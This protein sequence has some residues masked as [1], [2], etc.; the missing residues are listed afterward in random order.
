MPQHPINDH[1][2]YLIASPWGFYTYPFFA[3]PEKFRVVN[4]GPYLSFT[5]ARFAGF[6]PYNPVNPCRPGVACSVSDRAATQQIRTNRAR[7]SGT[8]PA[9]RPAG[10]GRRR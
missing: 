7:H 1:N 8:A 10:H 6:D 9:Q 5:G 2:D 4:S 3:Q